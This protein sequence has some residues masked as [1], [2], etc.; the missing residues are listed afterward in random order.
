MA[1]SSFYK[2]FV[3]KDKKVAQKFRQALLTQHPIKVEKKDLPKEFKRG[4][5]LLKNYSFH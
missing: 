5:E 2:S 4:I 3:I 1:T